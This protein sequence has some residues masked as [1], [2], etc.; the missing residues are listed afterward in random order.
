MFTLI[1]LKRDTK[2]C[3]RWWC[4]NLFSNISLTLT[5]KAEKCD[6]TFWMTHEST[7]ESSQ[8]WCGWEL[9]LCCASS[10][11]PCSRCRRLRCQVNYSSW[12]KKNRNE[13]CRGYMTQ[14]L[15]DIIVFLHNFSLQTPPLTPTPIS[16]HPSILPPGDSEEPALSAGVISWE[17]S[18]E[19]AA[20]FPWK[21]PTLG[22]EDRRR[23][24]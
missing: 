8:P 19:A 3:T 9:S 16:N 6:D 7:C 12:K 4:M 18:S 2:E 13:L 21:Q 5:A 22:E 15:W 20:W 1:C 10:G 11:S 14:F 17:P 23:M 24:C